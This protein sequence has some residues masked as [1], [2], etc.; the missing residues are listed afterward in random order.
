M[1]IGWRQFDTIESDFRQ[2]GWACSHDRAE[3]W[4]FTGSL[5]PGPYVCGSDLDRS[6]AGVIMF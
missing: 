1:A 4:T 6:L 2:A 5:E 3:T